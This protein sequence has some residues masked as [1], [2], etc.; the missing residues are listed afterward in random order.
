MF[1][2]DTKNPLLLFALI[3]KQREYCIVKVEADTEMMTK[4]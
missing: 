1:L 2:V 3:A 4:L